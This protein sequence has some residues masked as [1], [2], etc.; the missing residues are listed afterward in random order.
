MNAGLTINTLGNVYKVQNLP[1][2][3]TDS[4]FNKVIKTDSTGQF[5]LGDAFVYNVPN[6]ITVNHVNQPSDPD[7]PVYVQTIKDKLNEI[8]NSAIFQKFTNWN[9]ETFNGISDETINIQNNDTIQ[10]NVNPFRSLTTAVGG[11][12]MINVKSTKIL[13]S[14]Q[15][16]AITFNSII[17]T[18]GASAYGNY[19]I[20]GCRYVGIYSDD[21]GLVVPDFYFRDGG[22]G[23][24]GI[25]ALGL[26]G[27]NTQGIST[28]QV[29][30]YVPIKCLI[31]KVG[32]QIFLQAGYGTN[33]IISKIYDIQNLV[34][35]NSNFGFIVSAYKIVDNSNPYTTYSANVS[36]IQYTL[37]T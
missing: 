26:S 22:G 37:L 11:Q 5:A 21:N 30:W 15:N 31:L 4:N 17:S 35:N 12:T 8:H 3:S 1:D 2:R 16:W 32:T 23:D 36:N 19:G 14:S 29:G 20:P 25:P 28:R 33:N 7:V 18:D 6:T 13:S 24:F 27:D 34:N 9:I 10:T